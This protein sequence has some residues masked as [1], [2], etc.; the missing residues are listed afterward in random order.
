MTI[1]KDKWLHVIV[2]GVITIG[3]S[4]LLSWVAACFIT[5]AIGIAKELVDKYLRHGVFSYEDL[6]ANAFGIFCGAVIFALVAHLI[7]YK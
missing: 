3:L 6:R 2:C 1:P 4:F 5:F 7:G